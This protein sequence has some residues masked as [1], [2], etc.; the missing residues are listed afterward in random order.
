MHVKSARARCGGFN[1]SQGC[2]FFESL[3]VLAPDEHSHA[4]CLDCADYNERLVS[5]RREG[6]RLLAHHVIRS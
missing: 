6:A 3:T 2:L 1:V 5:A 4:T